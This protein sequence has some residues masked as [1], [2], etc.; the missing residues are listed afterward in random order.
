MMSEP[1]KEQ[2]VEAS[3]GS[4]GRLAA[5]G[6]KAVAG[7]RSVFVDAYGLAGLPVLCATIFASVT[8]G[9]LH[10]L[11]WWVPWVWYL[12]LSVVVFTMSR[13]A[14]IVKVLLSVVA[15]A[16]AV[17][18][19]GQVSTLASPNTDAY[20]SA[21]FAPILGLCIYWVA[22]QFG[23]YGMSRW[24]PVIP[25]LGV[26]TVVALFTIGF[27][28][29]PVIGAVV[30]LAVFLAVGLVWYRYGVKLF[31]RKSNMPQFIQPT[32]IDA[33]LEHDYRVNNPGVEEDPEKEKWKYIKYP[34]ARDRDPYTVLVVGDRAYMFFFVQLLSEFQL[35]EKTRALSGRV[36]SSRLTYRD[37]AIEP[38]LFDQVISRTPAGAT[39]ILVDMG[40]ANKS[41]KRNITLGLPDSPLDSSGSPVYYTEVGI[42]PGL[43]IQGKKAKAPL[44]E[45]AEKIYGAK[46]ALE[47]KAKA[48]LKKF[49]F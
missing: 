22:S 29:S 33:V 46:P 37:K 9:T 31:Y 2:T 40:N 43:D 5:L 7:L 6:G 28:L 34:P 10:S 26:S 23:N 27:T 19:L 21:A 41:D 13:A 36:K 1:G 16:Y 30:F 48:K 12:L 4:G 11:Q 38:W 47:D 17:T 32:T 20:I 35:V 49:R 15:T 25:V 14:I 39:P 45:R 24:S 18:I 42:I 3:R 44:L 8:A